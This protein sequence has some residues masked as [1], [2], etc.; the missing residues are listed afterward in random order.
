MQIRAKHSGAG[1]YRGSSRGRSES[2][3]TP[4]GFHSHVRLCAPGNVT[5][6]AVAHQ[7]FGP[8]LVNIADLWRERVAEATFVS[9]NHRIVRAGRSAWRSKPPAKA[10][11]PGAGDTG[12]RP[13]PSRDRPDRAEAPAQPTGCPCPQPSHS[14]RFSSMQ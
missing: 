6:S 10:G 5:L 7:W 3:T 9:Q 4:G 11:L 2:I 12:T 13:E 14:S 8:K 1:R